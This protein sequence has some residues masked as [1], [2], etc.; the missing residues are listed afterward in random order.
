MDMRNINPHGS[1][2]IL[3]CDCIVSDD[4]IDFHGYCNCHY[5]KVNRSGHTFTNMLCKRCG[6]CIKYIKLC[7]LCDKFKDNTFNI[8]DKYPVCFDCFENKN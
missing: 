6:G 5:P 1:D 3:D 8:D 7:W 2:P 4:P